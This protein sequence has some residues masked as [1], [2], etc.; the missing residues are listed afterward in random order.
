MKRL[1][2]VVLLALVA[3]RAFAQAQP[4][5]PPKPG[6]EVQRLA[7]MLGSWQ[8]EVEIRQSPLGPARKESGTT[9]CEWFTGSFQMVC[10]SESHDATGK[11]ASMSITAWDVARKTYVGF[12]MGSNGFVIQN[13]GQ[14]SGNTWTFTTE[15]PA[16][17][18]QAGR[19][20]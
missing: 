20:A 11:S 18:V 2:I 10:R 13:T 4:V 3:P 1:L 7:F 8:D 9:N 14:V 15:A 5:Q 6:P 17:G 12:G 16:P 19:T